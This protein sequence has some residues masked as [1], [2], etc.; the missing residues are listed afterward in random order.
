MTA[1]PR[2][3]KDAQVIDVI[4]ADE[5]FQLAKMGSRIVYT[6]AAEIAL[7]SGAAL[8]VKNTF[9]THAGTRVADIE[10][11]RPATA[12]TAIAHTTDI[13]RFVVDLEAEEGECVHIQR[14]AAVYEHIGAAGISLDMF[15]PAGD[16]LYFTVTASEAGQVGQILDGLGAHY[17]L[18]CALAKVTVI[19]AGMHG[20]PGVMAK[21]AAA[22]REDNIDIVQIADSHTTISVLVKAEE[23]TRAVCAL[24]K[25]FDLE[26]DCDA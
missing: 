2:V 24:H 8:L 23:G 17:Q 4:R 26:G 14:Q 9:S 21:I 1:D 7:R 5:L 6:P 11:A 25:A 18:T 20:K 19:G 12:A 3:V 22:L 16:K 10:S 13:A 15:T